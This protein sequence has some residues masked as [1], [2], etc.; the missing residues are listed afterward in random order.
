M[1]IVRPIGSELAYD[2]TVGM[3]ARR[4]TIEIWAFIC[5]CW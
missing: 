1:D 3:G 5:P 2:V 4:S